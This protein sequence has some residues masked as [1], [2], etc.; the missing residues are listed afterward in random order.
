MR[1]LAYDG[2]IDIQLMGGFA[3]P[4]HDP[5]L[6]EGVA[7]TGLSGL[8][9][10]SRHIKQKGA[11]Q[12]G[13]TQLDALYD[14]IAV[15]LDIECI[16]RD[17]KHLRR[18]VR[19]VI[20]SI[21]AKQQS[22]LGFFTHDMT[23]WWAPIR[24]DKSG[25]A[26][27]LGNQ[28]VNRQ[29]MALRLTA[30]NGF[31]RTYADTAMFRFFYGA[32]GLLEEFD[33]DYSGD[34][35]A[36]PNWPQW[37]DP[38]DG[39]GV[40]TTRG[41]ELVWDG[42][43]TTARQCILGPRKDYETASD[44]QIIEV[45]IGEIPQTVLANG[46]YDVVGGRMGRDVDDDWD[47][48]GVFAYF[49]RPQFTNGGE[50]KLVRF[51]NFVPTVMRAVTEV[52]MRTPTMREKLALVCGE[53]G[54]PR[55]FRL[56]RNGITILTHIETDEGSEL[57][58][59]FRG[60]GAGLV[61]GAGGSSQA[62]P[63]AIRRL[64]AGDNVAQAQGGF[65]KRWNVGDQSYYDDYTIFGPAEKVRIW[66]GPGAGPNDYVELGPLLANQV[67]FLRTDPRKPVIQ[68][69]TV[70]PATPQQLNIFQAALAGFLSFAFAG[71]VPPLLVGIESLFG[72]L[73]PQANLHSLV[74]GRFSDAAAI[75]ARSPGNPLQP[76]YVRVEVDGGNANTKIIASG[77]PLRRY[78]L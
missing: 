22:E 40:A 38:D 36:G 63:A 52:G 78:P 72:I 25:M 60:V 19:D 18:V 28:Q 45:E 20:A 4:F 49:G 51:N 17:Q 56:L 34:G 33:T 32:S 27:Q 29:P 46:A 73:P 77:V 58:A 15:E 13:A 31:W 71:N 39:A 7:V 10:P 54:N 43:G 65:L 16:A 42:S 64:T 14:E 53:E 55:V 5:M 2:S 74:S 37:Y 48:N 8:I 1:L 57:G 44:N 26:W 12:D 35:D 67:V 62:E 3:P 6:P 41:G 68:D 30:D 70:I 21:D 24:W 75:P 69:L 47:G 11:T 76:Y 61:A 59:D 9:P 23:Y 66:N 50:L